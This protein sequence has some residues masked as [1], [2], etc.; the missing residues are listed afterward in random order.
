[1]ELS[2]IMAS[3]LLDLQQTV[4][5]SVM[6]SALNMHTTAAVEM[7][8]ELPQQQTATHPIKGTAIDVSV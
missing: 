5:L 1:M 2:S 3:Q 4:Q 7:L 8:R 6:Q